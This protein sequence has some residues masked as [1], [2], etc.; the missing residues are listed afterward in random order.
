M[1]IWSLELLCLGLT[2]AQCKGG[3]DI[4]WANNK[5]YWSRDSP[6]FTIGQTK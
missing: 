3:A 1:Q 4:G 6:Y 5:D 2:N